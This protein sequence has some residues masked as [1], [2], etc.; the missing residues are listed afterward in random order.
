VTKPKPSNWRISRD[1]PELSE[2]LRGVVIHSA[3][4]TDPQEGPLSSRAVRGLSETL[5][6]E[7]VRLPVHTA[8]KTAASVRAG[9]SVLSW[10]DDVTGK[11]PVLKRVEADGAITL[12]SL[13][14]RGAARDLL[15]RGLRS[16]I[17]TIDA[18]AEE[19]EQLGR[20]KRVLSSVKIDGSDPVITASGRTRSRLAAGR[21]QI[22][23]LAR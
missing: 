2:A 1:A 6:C 16:S 23:A 22:M 9:Y 18:A 14:S 20:D 10:E 12:Q 8:W 17:Y 7:P 19:A 15:A 11:Q 4:Q 21:A 13:W 3:R 5:P